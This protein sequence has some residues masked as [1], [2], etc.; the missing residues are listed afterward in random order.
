MRAKPWASVCPV[1]TC[2][3]W[4]SD[5]RSAA[6]CTGL[7]LS[8]EVTQTPEF[9]GAILKCTARFVTSTPVR[10]YIGALRPSSASPRRGDSISTTW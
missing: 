6:P 9:T 10:T 1:Q 2:L 5:T 3:P 8:S 7:P 4:Q